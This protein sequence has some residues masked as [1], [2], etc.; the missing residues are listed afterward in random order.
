[1]VTANCGALPCRVGWSCRRRRWSP[2]VVYAAAVALCGGVMIRFLRR[3]R[4]RAID[5][6]YKLRFCS[7][8][9]FHH[10]SSSERD[11]HNI[12]RHNTARSSPCLWS[13]I[14]FSCRY[15][16]RCFVNLITCTYECRIAEYQNRATRH[17]Q[18]ELHVGCIVGSAF[19]SSPRS[20]CVKMRHVRE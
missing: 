12:T 17:S 4:R 16:H 6:V 19:P 7:R 11:D 10:A 13:P 15:G 5:F 8:H 1:M 14:T 3:R 18:D 20:I 2:S 9:L